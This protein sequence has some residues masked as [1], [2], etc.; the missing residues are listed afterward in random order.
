MYWLPH[1]R[2]I[3]NSVILVGVLVSVLL[4]LTTEPFQYDARPSSTT[5]SYHAKETLLVFPPIKSAITLDPY[6]NPVPVLLL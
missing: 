4:V 1:P 6:D 5:V 3:L 2:P